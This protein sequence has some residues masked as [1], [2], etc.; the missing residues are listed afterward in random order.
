MVTDDEAQRPLLNDS[1]CVLACSTRIIPSTGDEGGVD[2]CLHAVV[3]RSLITRPRKDVV[4]F[5]EGRY[6]QMD[7]RCLNRDND[8][9]HCRQRLSIARSGWSNNDWACCL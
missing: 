2:S 7:A 9:C 1:H 3:V 6:N 4:W 8:H 5:V